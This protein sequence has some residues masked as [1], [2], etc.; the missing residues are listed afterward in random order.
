[1]LLRGLTGNKPFK[2][3][4]EAE[5]EHSFQPTHELPVTIAPTPSTR[6]R[7]LAKAE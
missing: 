3:H 2:Q 5:S 4:G 6:G 7:E 1:V